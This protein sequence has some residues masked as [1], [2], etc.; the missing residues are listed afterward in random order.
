MCGMAGRG[1]PE[2]LGSDVHEEVAAGYCQDQE[3]QVGHPRLDRCDQWGAFCI[4]SIFCGPPRSSS[5][6]SK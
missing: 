3:E 1:I 2:K 6:C 5:T 4:G